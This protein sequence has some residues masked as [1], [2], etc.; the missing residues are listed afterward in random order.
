MTRSQSSLLLRDGR[1]EWWE[2][3]T[4]FPPCHHSPRASYDST[5]ETTGHEPV[6]SP[7]PL[8]KF[9][10]VVTLHD[11]LKDWPWE[12]EDLVNIIRS[13]SQNWS[14]IWLTAWS[15]YIPSATQ[16]NL[17]RVKGQCFHHCRYKNLL[18]RKVNYI[19]MDISKRQR[20]YPRHFLRYLYR[21]V[22]CSV[23][24][25]ALIG[26]MYVI[27]FFLVLRQWTE[28]R[29]SCHVIVRHLLGNLRDASEL[30]GKVRHR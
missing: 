10:L 11:S 21:L 3:K 20:K 26:E 9:E 12:S 7:L 25:N 16:S 13:T 30:F 22:H 8:P 5:R 23:W 1:E 29:S 4:R 28:N 24:I 2:W 18:F 14:N 6:Y 19:S 17:P 27:T 15:N